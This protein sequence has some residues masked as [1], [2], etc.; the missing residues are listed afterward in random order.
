MAN[1]IRNPKEAAQ[2][3]WWPYDE[4]IKIKTAVRSRSA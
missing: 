3:E 2:L 1:L 4:K